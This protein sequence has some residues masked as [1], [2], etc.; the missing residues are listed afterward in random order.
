MSALTEGPTQ[1]HRLGVT[2]PAPVIDVEKVFKNYPVRGFFD[3]FRHG[4]ST[5][6]SKAVRD[7]YFTVFSV[8]EE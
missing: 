8:E 6:G 3:F 7:I 2:R 1:R 5:R 4:P